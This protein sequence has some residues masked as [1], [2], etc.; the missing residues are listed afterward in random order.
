MLF[1]KKYYYLVFVWIFSFFQNHAQNVSTYAGT[2]VA[3]L[4]A[5]GTDRLSVM[6][7]QPHDMAYD[8]KGNL[9]ITERGGHVLKVILPNG[10]SYIR[11]GGYDHA[12]F[13]NASSITSR[14]HHPQGIAID[15]DDNIYIADYDNHAI[16]KVTAYQN[17]GNAQDVTVHAGKWSAPSPG[18]PNCYTSHPG[19]ADGNPEVA[20]FNY[21]SDLTIDPSGNIYVADELNHAI[22]KILPT[23]VVS[24]LCGH[25][26]SFGF[27]DGSLSM[28][29]FYYPKG[30]LYHNNALYVADSWN[31]RIRKIDLS[32]GQVSTLVS[33]LWLPMDMAFTTDGSLIIIDQHRLRKYKGGILSNFAGSP[34]NLSGDS[35]GYGEDAKFNDAKGI[36]FDPAGAQLFLADQGNNKIKRIIACADFKPQV[37]VDGN[38]TFCYGDS[39]RLVGQSGYKDYLWS[40]MEKSQ[41]IY[42]SATASVTLTVTDSN[43]CQGTSNPVNVTRRAQIVPIITP[44]GPTTFYDGDSVVL[45][46]PTSGY[47]YYRW[48]RNELLFNQGQGIQSIVVKQSGT[49]KLTVT[50]AFT[51]CQGTSAPLPVNV[52]DTDVPGLEL[53]G[54][55]AL[56]DGDSLIIRTRNPYKEYLWNTGDS[57]RSIVVK[58]SGMFFVRITRDDNSQAY[59]DTIIVKLYPLPQKPVIQVHYNNLASSVTE[60]SYQWYLNDVPI[61]GANQK[62]YEITESG[63]YSVMAINKHGCGNLS[64]TLYVTYSHTN[65]SDFLENI[66]IFPNP[67]NGKVFISNIDREV[68]LSVRDIFGREIITYQIKQQE[69]IL[70]LTFLE[71]GIY[72]LILDDTLQ[73]R[74]RKLILQ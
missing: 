6:I 33:G 42:V 52:L 51:S 14:F 15:S 23:G 11:A 59:S 68:S 24:T 9:W 1:M 74:A 43:Q 70:D 63:Y 18:N 34:V 17:L 32:S 62:E 54:D 72:F 12:C 55:T 28:A 60:H 4:G 22:R 66:S 2:G 44:D 13:K 65:H 58:Q 57:S 25:P 39:V 53:T 45:V 16:R 36:I 20:Q 10:Q 21:P 49:Y 67:S 3:G 29:K 38:A 69:Q 27:R 73:T 50:D 56:C 64:D 41:A 7:N 46:G 31:Q 8:S 48:T 71:R 19:F 30:I 40:T 47:N 61:S 35:D 37:T 26:D 5:N